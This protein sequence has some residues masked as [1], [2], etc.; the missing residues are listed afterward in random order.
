MLPNYDKISVW[1][2]TLNHNPKPVSGFGLE[3]RVSGREPRVSIPAFWVFF[4]TCRGVEALRSG[5]HEYG[6]ALSGCAG[7]DKGHMAS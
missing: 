5:L 2:L 4:Q 7:Y 3:F 1:G 6:L